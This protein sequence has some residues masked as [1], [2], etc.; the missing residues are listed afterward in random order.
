M[1]SVGV[2]AAD[3]PSVWSEGE[4]AAIELLESVLPQQIREGTVLRAEGISVSFGG[5]RALDDVS[6]D[7]PAHSFVG[8][9]GPNGSGKSTLFDVINGFTRPDRGR[10]TAFGRDV[11]RLPAWSLARL[12]VSR[13]FQANHIDPDRTVYENLLA[14]AY[15]NIVGG[16]FA[17]IL[18]FPGPRRDLRQA[19]VIAHAVARLLDL[20]AVLGVRAGVLS[21]GAQRR[22]EIGRG[23]MGRPR[24]LLL[25]EP[26]AGMDAIEAQHLLVL[27]K[28]LQID[29][30]LAVFLIEHFVRMVLDHCGLVHAIASGRIIASGPPGDIALDTGVQEAYLGARDA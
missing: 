12:G 2:S 9:I 22:T 16:V 18:Q 30:G 6:I 8:L 5:V 17:S 25:D 28:R 19:D 11:T 1:T 27:V 21:F 7:V 24:L 4:A 29:L 13:T 10:V 20:E 3:P 14:G 26:S 15:L 23:L